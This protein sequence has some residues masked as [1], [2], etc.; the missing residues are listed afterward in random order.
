VALVALLAYIIVQVINYQRAQDYREEM[1]DGVAYVVSQVIARQPTP[2]SQL[3]WMMDVSRVLELPLDLVPAAKLDTSRSERRRLDSKHAIVRYND[4]TATGDIYTRVEGIPDAYLHIQVNKLSEVQIKMIPILIL[5]DLV[6]YPGS[7]EQRLKELQPYFPYPLSF[8][9]LSDL[10]LD[11]D[12]LSRLRMDKTQTILLYRDSAT[13]QGTTI[14]AVSAYT[15]VPNKV[16][17]LGPVP[18]FNWL[19]FRLFASITLFSLFM[20]ILGVYALMRPLEHKIGKVKQAL[21]EVRS[22]NLDTRVTVE[23]SD[24]VANLGLS[25]NM[26]TEHIQ[27]LIEA[28]RE[29]TRAVSHELRTPV[30]RVRFGMEML[31]DTD[32]YDSRIKQMEMIDKDIEALNSLIDEIMT[33]AKLEQGTPSLHIETFALKG[34]LEQVLQETEVI[35]KDKKITSQLPAEDIMVET[36]YRYLHR[37]IQ[38]FVGNA[39]RYCNST[40]RVSGGVN[41]GMA[42]VA[43]EDDGAG[44]PE[45]DREKVFEA[46]ARLDDS[47]TR[48]SGGY[49]LGL[50]IVSRIAYW[51]G[52]SVTVDESPLLGGARF[53][54]TWPAMRSTENKRKSRRSKKESPI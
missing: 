24:E 6:Y 22:G 50:S 38:N 42:F 1:A 4:K 21:N 10:Y 45:K 48:A 54:M 37:V 40:V 27:R 34:V 51:F 47:R 3:D 7:E 17:V 44:I 26:M 53:V 41:N 49:G 32:D 29:L 20:L 5:E 9:N 43:V 12:Q 13:M 25:F 52:G 30:A 23:G 35:K 11:M 14:T 15:N 39:L 2:Q 46:F 19:P 8:R 18:V 33:Y 28:Q 31:A 36:E 16:L